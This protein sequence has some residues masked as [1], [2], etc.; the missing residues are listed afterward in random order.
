M[1][2][3]NVPLTPAECANSFSACGYDPDW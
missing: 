1:V 2:V 3:G